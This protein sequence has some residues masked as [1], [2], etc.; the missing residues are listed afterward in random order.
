MKVEQI[1]GAFAAANHKP[2]AEFGRIHHLRSFFDC[3]RLSR[4]RSLLITFHFYPLVAG[5]FFW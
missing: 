5:A 2:T 4:T 3:R 1:E